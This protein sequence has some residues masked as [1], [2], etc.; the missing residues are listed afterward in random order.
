MCTGFEQQKRKDR[1]ALGILF[2]LRN[3][4]AGRLVQLR[5]FALASRPIQFDRYCSN[6]HE[7]VDRNL[8]MIGRISR[9][10]SFEVS[11]RLQPH[12][13]IRSEAR[14]RIS[15]ATSLE[16]WTLAPHWSI[17]DQYRIL[18]LVLCSIFPGNRSTDIEG[19]KSSSYLRTTCQAEARHLAVRPSVS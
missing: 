9:W 19:G 4:C 13:H 2:S 14:V 7:R 3:C 17:V 15:R 11:L 8:I 10:I 16:E 6:G 18:S 1:K 12:S 5:P